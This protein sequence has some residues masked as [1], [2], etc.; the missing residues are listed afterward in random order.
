MHKKTKQIV[1]VILFFSFVIVSFFS[2]FYIIKESNH[3]CSGERCSVC[4]IINKVKHSLEQILTG[5]SALFVFVNKFII[6]LTVLFLAQF[7]F[8][9]TTPVAQKVRM[10][11]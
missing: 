9:Y 10:N 1:A 6:L 7:V 11:N 2:E 4:S 8:L 3:E 5:G